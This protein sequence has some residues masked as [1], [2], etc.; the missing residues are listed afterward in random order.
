MTIPESLRQDC[1]RHFPGSE[2]FEVTGD[3]ID[4]RQR[5]KLAAELCAADMDALIAA[6]GER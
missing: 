6:T 3:L 1:R 4:S 2:R 5:W